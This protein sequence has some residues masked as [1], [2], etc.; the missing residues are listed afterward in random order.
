MSR[1]LEAVI[2]NSRWQLP[3]VIAQYASGTE[4]KPEHPHALATLF[5]RLGV[6]R[7]FTEGVAE[8]L[9]VAQMQA[10]AA[11]LHG[12]KL[13][14]DQ[15]KVTSRAAA[16]WDSVGGQ[17]WSAAAEIARHSR[18]SQNPTWE[19]EDD[20]L[21]IAFVMTR[22]FLVP[23]ED[24]NQEDHVRAQQRMLARWAEVLDGAV[25]PRLDLCRALIDRDRDAFWEAL[26]AIA[27]QRDAEVQLKVER[28]DLLEDDAAWFG[29]FW[30]EGLGLLRL[31]ERE[32]MTFDDG[33]PMVPAIC[34]AT[35]GRA[36]DPRSWTRPDL[37]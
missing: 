16:F 21:Y 35:N 25:D 24:V 5:R 17:Y 6:A 37:L 8:P 34:R 32:G 14:A 18:M 4:L 36:Y 9:F 19:H 3:T 10:S 15:D 33:C 20:F 27:E 28:R 31:A 13:L 30:G 7:M 26:L 11:Y 1:Q 12:L 23:A 2:A 22:Y 29:P